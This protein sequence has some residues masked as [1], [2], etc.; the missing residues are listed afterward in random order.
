MVPQA[1]AP[2]QR[3]LLGLNEDV[4][5]HIVSDLPAR[6]ALNL[7][8]TAHGIHL[9]AKRHALSV[10]T[11]RSNAAIVRIC[12]YMLGDIPGRLHYVRELTINVDFATSTVERSPIVTRSEGSVWNERHSD[13]PAVRVLVPLL[14]N[15]INLRSLSLSPMDILL[16]E[17]PR[18]GPAISAITQLRYLDLKCLMD[19]AESC[20]MLQEMRSRPEE[21]GLSA[22]Y[23][24]K[25]INNI[26]S[27]I[28]GMQTIKS[29]TLSPD[30]VTGPCGDLDDC[31]RWPS[32]STLTIRRSCL[33][34]TLAARVFPNVRKL[35]VASPYR[36]PEGASWSSLDYLDAPVLF[37]R[38]WSLP[39]AVHHISVQSN[40]V[41]CDSDIYRDFKSDFAGHI[42][43]ILRETRPKVVSLPVLPW[44]DF[45]RAFWT[46]IAEAVPSLRSLEVELCIFQ[47]ETDLIP[48][49][50]RYM[51]KRSQ[52]ALSAIIGSIDSLV[53]IRISVRCSLMREI[54]Y[55]IRFPTI[56]DPFIPTVL[57]ADQMASAL[58]EHIPSLRYV[59]FL[60]TYSTSGISLS[61]KIGYSE[62]RCSLVPIPRHVAE[63]VKARIHALDFD[64]EVDLNGK[65]TGPWL[66]T[67]DHAWSIAV[68]AQTARDMIRP[69]TNTQKDSEVQVA[70]SCAE[71]DIAKP[72]KSSVRSKIWS[73]LQ[74]GGDIV[75]VSDIGVT[76]WEIRIRWRLA[77]R[78]TVCSIRVP[79][80]G[81]AF[82]TPGSEASSKFRN[83][84]YNDQYECTPD[85][86][87][88]SPWTPLGVSASG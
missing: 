69:P 24:P 77:T 14:E 11:T 48:R 5:S 8:V 32:V 50:I 59:T 61:W 80:S 76:M 22:F 63:D 60:S 47:D 36:D 40:S 42:V 16:H 18:I 52:G 15:A 68:G 17:Q 33:P 25:S 13:E 81:P 41:H 72:V 84:G 23:H 19:D 70:A 86:W 20:R 26:L 12:T 53:H 31:L 73:H 71:D 43:R 51:L 54:T 65:E 3:G 39:C 35:Q 45:N 10:V 78:V 67:Y 66:S 27:S 85:S 30:G 9:I 28:R 87:A 46:D 82:G 64:P 83:L 57:E 1:S 75:R 49:L 88:S 21:V 79:L 4:L 62:D 2:D 55:P 29:F 74:R 44:P 6:D 37:L 34:I 7:S 38:D 58:I 56:P